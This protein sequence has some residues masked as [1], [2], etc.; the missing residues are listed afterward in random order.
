MAFEVQFLNTS[1]TARRRFSCMSQLNAG[2]LHLR[3]SKVPF[4]IPL[5]IRPSIIQS[6]AAMGSEIASAKEQNA[7][8]VF[9]HSQVVGEQLNNSLAVCSFAVSSQIAT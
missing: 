3:T 9:R 1:M 5:P 7:S 2:L 4:E 8:G 6:S